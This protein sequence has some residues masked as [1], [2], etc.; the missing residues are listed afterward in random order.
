MASPQCHQRYV[1]QTGIINQLKPR[2]LSE[3][4]KTADGSDQ[5]KRRKIHELM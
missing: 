1:Y 2:S 4:F 5:I 3:R